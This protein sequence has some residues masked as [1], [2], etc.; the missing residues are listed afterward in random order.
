MLFYTYGRTTPDEKG[1][2]QTS[3]HLH[4]YE[5]DIK[6]LTGPIAVATLQIYKIVSN[7]FL[8]T[9]EKFHYLF[10]LRDVAKVIQGVLMASP[11]TVDTSE[12]MLRLW[13]HECQRVFMDRFVRTKTNDEK[14]FMDVMTSQMNAVFQKD[15]VSIL[16]DSLDPK[17]GP[18]FCAFMQ[19]KGEEGEEGNKGT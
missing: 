17:V 12:R 13:V 6:A 9:P 15:L 10:N 4:E 3:T 7:D 16:A 18:L 1:N 19:E 5:D 8:A 14:K 2:Y 11:H